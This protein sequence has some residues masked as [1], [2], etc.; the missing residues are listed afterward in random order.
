MSGSTTDIPTIVTTAGMQPN[1]P[2]TLNELLLTSV[3]AIQP[4]YTANLPGSLIED[5]SST[6]TQA[7]V[8][9]DQAR[10]EFFNS[11]TPYGA[12]QFILNQLG[13]IYG[14]LQGQATNTS[15]YVVFTGT[16]GFPINPGFTV[17]DG[18]Y[19]YVVQDGGVV[20]TGGSSQPLYC[21]ATQSGTW[22]VPANTVTALSTSLPSGISLTCTNPTTGTPGAALQDWATYRSEVLQGGLASA[23]G[24]PSLLKTLLGQVNGVQA[25]L[26]SVQQGEGTYKIICG[27]GDPYAVANAIYSAAF[28]VSSLIGSTLQ[29][30]GITNANP[31]VMT[32]NLNHGY[33]TGQ[34]I[35]VTGV[36]GMSGI[37]GV[38]L[39]I[40]VI[41]E[42]SFSLG[43]NTTSSG[44]YT[45]GGVVTPNL[46]NVSVNIYDYPDT[47]AIPFVN[48][49]QETVAM[50][51]VWNTSSPNFVSN[52]AVTQAV[53]PA[54]ANYVN[55]VP[56]GQPMN[57]FELQAVFQAA[58]VSIL[59]NQLLTRMV[60]TVQ[61]NGV[62]VSPESGTG[63]IA[64]DPES[65]FYTTQTAITV[66][67][68]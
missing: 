51:V 41:T 47:Y 3:A 50:A 38:P 58:T 1:T 16:V 8:Q 63:I 36:V 22:A 34:V 42:N 7:L 26:V 33:T 55:S 40:T 62:T 14:V 59:P 9:I 5:I 49:P 10:V 52:S 11:L 48:P 43:I 15:V 65:Y 4:G 28:D 25:R 23:Q 57:L 17:S 68:G 60:F 45:S 61:I 54:L 30:T 18:T 21:V 31:G 56:V 32:T 27:G 19:Q 46:R 44:T 37:N 13:V 12:N 53:Q 39:T 66:S 67:Q 24:M 29:V 20:Q 35:N 6:D 2:A 64:G